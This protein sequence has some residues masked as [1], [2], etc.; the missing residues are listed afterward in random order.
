LVNM[1]DGQGNSQ[2]HGTVYNI[3][4]W[5]FGSGLG[6]IIAD[7]QAGDIGIIAVIDRDISSVKNTNGQQSNPSSLRQFSLSDGVYLGTL[8][9]KAPKQ[10]IVF[11]STG[12]SIVDINHNS[13]GSGHAGWAMSGNVTLGSAAKPIVFTVNGVPMTIP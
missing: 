2:S 6:Q 5:R 3:P 10:Y 12:I 4:I 9:G 13:F 7:P 8:F 11:T 1:L